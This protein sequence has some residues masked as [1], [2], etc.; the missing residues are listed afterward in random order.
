M[1]QLS[2]TRFIALLPLKQPLQREFM[3]RCIASS[4]GAGLSSETSQLLPIA[5]VNSSI[6]GT[7]SPESNPAGQM[8]ALLGKEE[9]RRFI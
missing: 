7:A 6:R 4:A 3:L 9:M 2:R 8:L 5:L 1:R